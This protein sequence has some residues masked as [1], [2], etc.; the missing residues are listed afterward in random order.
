MLTLFAA[1]SRGS[2]APVLSNC[3]YSSSDGALSAIAAL[4]CVRLMVSLQRVSCHLR[5]STRMVTPMPMP[6][7]A[8]AETPDDAKLTTGLI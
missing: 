4:F 7:V 3:R 2:S 8:S 6:S 1:E 5:N